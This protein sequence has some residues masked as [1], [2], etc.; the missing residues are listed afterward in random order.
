M[1]AYAGAW[2]SV[3]GKCH[4][5]AYTSDDDGRPMG[6]PLPVVSTGWR[7]AEYT[8]R[9]HYVDACERRSRELEPRPRRVKAR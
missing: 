7:Y 1:Q 6:C 3:R 8:G 4:G 2:Q 5:F 9:W